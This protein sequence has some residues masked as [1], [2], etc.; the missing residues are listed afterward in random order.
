MATFTLPVDIANRALQIIGVPRIMLF[1][2]SSKAARETSFAIDKVRQANLRRSIWTFATRRAVLRPIISGS[3]LLNVL[4][5]SAATTY[6]IGDIVSDSTGFLWHSVQNSNTANTPGAGGVNP[7]WISYYGTR[8]VSAWGATV[9]YFPGDL[10]VVAA[11]IY[12]C[13]QANL[14]HTPPNATYWHVVAGATG[15]AIPFLSPLGVNP[16]AGAT[17]RNVYL[18]PANYIRI[19]PQDPKAAANVRAGTAAGMLY[20]DWEIE[21][22]F[23]FTNDP[24]PIIFRFVA[25]ETDV[26]LMDALFCEVWAAHLAVEVCET[27]TQSVEKLNNATGRYDRALSMA[28]AMNAIEEGSSEPEVAEGAGQQAP[29]G[30]PAQRGQ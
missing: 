28:K 19:A 11:V 22:G 9:A 21:A 7:F 24:S 1:T 30:Q 8:A 13:V 27:L 25:D 4:A 10:V 12:I 3:L 23:L 29:Q 5:Y 26:T 20:N 6:A 15:T 2:D 14:N 18:L 17:T 16:P